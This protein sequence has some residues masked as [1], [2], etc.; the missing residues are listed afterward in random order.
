[1]NVLII[2]GSVFVGRHI[3]D[4]LLSAGHAVTHFNR[5]VSAPPRDD[6]ET[7]KGNR[8]V[9]LDRLGD[10][11]W[12]A[13]V[14]TCGYVPGDVRLSTER[15]KDRAGQYLFISTVSVYDHYRIEDGAPVDEAAATAVLAPN[16]DDTVVTGETYGALKVLC[17]DVVADT[18]AENATIVRGGVMVGP[19]DTTDRFTYWVARCARGG[20]MLAPGGSN[21]PMQFIDVRDL[22]AFVVRLLEN[23][24]PGTLNVTGTPGTVTFGELFEFTIRVAGLR[25][26]II[27]LDR[28]TIARSGLTVGIDWCEIPLWIQDPGLMTKYHDV[29]VDR[30]LAVGL[31]LRPLGDT[32]RDTLAWAQTRPSGYEMKHGMTLER[33]AEALAGATKIITSDRT[34]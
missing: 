6:V 16:A 18:F 24:T 2:G 14:D 19:Y 10:Q 21:E 26:D 5:G 7:V 22:A 11:T 29:R 28:E 30:A 34:G 8:T 33:E 27:W 20:R 9:D 3:T 15:L 17:E 31:K 25:P 12:D 4:A 13:V 32:V 23:R 1:M